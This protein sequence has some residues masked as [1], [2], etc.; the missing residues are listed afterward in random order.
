MPWSVLPAWKSTGARAAVGVEIRLE[1]LDASRVEARDVNTVVPKAD[2]EG[3]AT[4]EGLRPRDH[5]RDR[6]DTK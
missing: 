1:D 5:D 2:L 3:Q 6:E 4:A